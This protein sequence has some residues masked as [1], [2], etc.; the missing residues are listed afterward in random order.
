MSDIKTHK[1]LDIWKIGIELV[2]KIYEMKSKFP[3]TERFGLT[4]QMRRCAVSIPANISEGAARHSKK[5]FIQFL[6]ISLGS[7]A[8]LETHLIIAEK[9]N[10]ADIKEAIDIIEILRPKILNFIKYQKSKLKNG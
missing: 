3:E 10:Y 7:L 2:L 1:D 5:E 8:E 4:S 6:Y 9:I